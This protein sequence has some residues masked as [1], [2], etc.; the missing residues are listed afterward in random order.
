[1]K[2]RHVGAIAGLT[3]A[4]LCLSPSALGGTKMDIRGIKVSI[5]N[6]GTAYWDGDGT[7]TVETYFDF[8]KVKVAA[9]SNAVGGWGWYCDL[10]VYSDD[11]IVSAIQAKGTSDTYLY[12]VGQTYY[13]D[14]FKG[15]LTFIGDTDTYGPFAGLGMTSWNI[16]GWPFPKQASL[17]G[18][19]TTAHFLSM[20]V[21]D[22]A[23]AKS[24]ETKL[25][26]AGIDVLFGE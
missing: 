6:G 4:L 8:A 2:T 12:V 17:K 1:M 24:L 11:Q 26:K 5:S 7:L 10:Y 9:S 19:W 16:E 18:G 13:C 21:H 22:T 23:P 20:D 3:A 15:V 25:S 14:S